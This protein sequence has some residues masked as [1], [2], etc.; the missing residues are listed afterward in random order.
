MLTK[1]EL[2]LMH[3]KK[4]NCKYRN[5]YKFSNLLPNYRVSVNY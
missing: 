4:K 1:F 5:I 2:K 3:K